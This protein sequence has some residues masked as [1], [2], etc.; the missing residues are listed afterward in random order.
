M[1]HVHQLGSSFSAAAAVPSGL[2]PVDAFKDLLSVYSDKLITITD[3]AAAKVAAADHR[4]YV[5]RKDA[6]FRIRKMERETRSVFDRVQ[7]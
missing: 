7:Q 1:S 2:V 4:A 3:V 5:S 6:D